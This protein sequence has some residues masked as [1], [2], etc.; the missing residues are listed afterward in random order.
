MYYGSKAGAKG[1]LEP[2]IPY[3]FTLLT[4]IKRDPFEQTDSAKSFSG[5]GGA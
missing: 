1:W 5:F 2:L 4:N 3:H